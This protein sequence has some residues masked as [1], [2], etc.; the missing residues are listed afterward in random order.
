MLLLHHGHIIPKSWVMSSNVWFC[1]IQK[2][3]MY[4]TFDMCT[5]FK[6]CRKNMKY[7]YDYNHPYVR[8]HNSKTN[9]SQK[10]HSM[11]NDTYTNISSIIDLL[12]LL[13][14]LLL[15]FDMNKYV[16]MPLSFTRDS[17]VL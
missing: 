17:Q 11:I 3:D 9:G 14:L 6:L 2:S 13:L 4:I 16:K 8:T 10:Q 5:Y 1:C 7:Y 15:L 12:L